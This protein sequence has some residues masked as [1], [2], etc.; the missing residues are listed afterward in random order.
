MRMF[1]FVLVLF[2]SCLGFA[3]SPEEDEVRAVLDQ[4]VAAWNRGDLKGYMAGYWDSPDLVF[5][6]GAAVTHGWAPTLKRY[7][8]RYQSKGHR[9]G[10]LSFASIQIEVLA[11]DAAFARGRWRLKGTAGNA[12]RGLFTLM[13]RKLPEGWRIVHDHSSAQ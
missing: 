10:K 4:Q 12:S 8:Q 3:A 13:L 11:P 1:A 2:C 9:M 7:R 6:S 5:Y